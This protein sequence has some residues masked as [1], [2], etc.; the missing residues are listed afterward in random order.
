MT[1]KMVLGM[2]AVSLLAAA[3]VALAQDHAAPKAEEVPVLPLSP[4]HRAAL[5]AEMVGVKEVVAELSGRLLWASGRRRHS[6][7]NAS[8]TVTS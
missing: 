4:K 8:A 3:N 7:P 2:V 5:V 6:A 1:G